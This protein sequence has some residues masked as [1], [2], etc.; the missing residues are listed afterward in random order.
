MGSLQRG[1]TNRSYGECTGGNERSC[2]RQD[3]IDAA[4]RFEKFLSPSA[5]LP[6]PISLKFTTGKHGGM[7]HLVPN[8]QTRTFSC[9]CTIIPE[10]FAARRRL[11]KLTEIT[12]GSSLTK[13]KCVYDK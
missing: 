11:A 13:Q 7:V 4:A 5:S 3:G 12:D 2:R 1:Q 9:F 10:R 6:P 8:R